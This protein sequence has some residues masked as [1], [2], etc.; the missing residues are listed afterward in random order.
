MQP[1]YE[2]IIGRGIGTI[3]FGVSREYLSGI[4]GEPDEVDNSEDEKKFEWERYNYDS[5]N[6]SFS[7]DPGHEDR[8]V[9]IS[10]EN[11]YFHIR[12]KIRVGV[13]KAELLKAAAELDF[14]EPVVEDASDEEFRDR[15]TISYASNGLSFLLDG[16]IITI[17]RFSPLISKE[18]KI[19]WPE[20][21][22]I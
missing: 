7:F 20:L 21:E 6:C 9:E 10:V 11:G 17:I 16:G 1:D 8:L 3:L 14:G 15:E 18:G 13:S 12:H 19:I 22:N 5:I 4:L 2:I